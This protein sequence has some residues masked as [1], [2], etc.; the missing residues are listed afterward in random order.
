MSASR[1]VFS[2][3]GKQR[4]PHQHPDELF[5]ASALVA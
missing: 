5:A 1:S 2:V 4:R 3:D